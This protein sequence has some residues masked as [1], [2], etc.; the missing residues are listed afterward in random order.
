MHEYLCLFLKW[1]QKGRGVRHCRTP[2]PTP[3]LVSVRKAEDHVFQI[4]QLPFD[5]L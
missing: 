3:E 4:L 5:R 2:R 1:Y